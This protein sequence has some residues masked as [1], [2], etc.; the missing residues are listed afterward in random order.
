MRENVFATLVSIDENGRP[1]L[2]HLPLLVETEN[3]KITLI[4]HM[5]KANPQIRH[6]ENG[7][8]VQVAFH[9]PHTYI[10]PSWYTDPMNVPTWNYA[11][12]HAS[13]KPTLIRD[14]KTLR[15]ILER[16][17]T[18]FEKWEKKPW[19]LDLPDEFIGNL[20]KAIVGFT[21]EVTELEGKFK[22]S[23][24]RAPEDRDGV[25]KG[26]ASRTDEMSRKVLALMEK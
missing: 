10:T 17:V 14:S 16:T 25:L 19:K 18:E 8:Q 3:E 6:F 11:A 21:I 23:Q 20:S 24:N 12:V 13:G 26:L 2:N 7:S 1:F 4:G 5:A 22:L 15:S 9:G